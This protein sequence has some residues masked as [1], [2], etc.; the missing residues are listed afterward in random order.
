MIHKWEEPCVSGTDPERGSGAVFFMHCT[1]GCVYCQNRVISRRNSHKEGSTGI[2]PERLAEI[3]LELQGKGAW[4]I[5]LVT[6]GHYLPSVIDAVELARK[7][8][9]SLPIVYNTGGYET[10]DN[11]RR[12]E[13]VVDVFLTDMKY[14][15]AGP[16]GKYSFAPDYCKAAWPALAEMF[17]IT[18]E[19]LEFG[20]DGMLKRG[21]IVRHLVLPGR[22]YAAGKIIKKLW[23]A[24]GDG[25]VYSLMNQ[26]TPLPELSPE[27][28]EFPEL[29][30]PVSEEEYAEAR[31]VLEGLGPEHA[32][33]QEGGTVS[34]SFIPLW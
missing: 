10:V 22:S 2:G 26:Y 17:R 1:L 23:R 12:L 13:G 9:L 16:A 32:Y 30:R 31:E 7:S 11:I 14:L 27:L 18:G 6:P 3:F 15:T 8:G 5:N 34:E 4:N 24:Y 28:A 25:I 29:L 20:Q 19:S 33:V 21:V